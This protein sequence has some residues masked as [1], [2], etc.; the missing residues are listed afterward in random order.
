[1]P[2]RFECLIINNGSDN[3]IEWLAT[4]KNLG[5]WLLKKL[6][7]VPSQPYQIPDA[8]TNYLSTMPLSVDMVNQLPVNV[9]VM[10]SLRNAAESSRAESSDEPVPVV[11]ELS[12]SSLPHKQVEVSQPHYF[13]RAHGR[14]ASK[15]MNHLALLAQNSEALVAVSGNIVVPRLDVCLQVATGKVR[16]FTTGTW[17]GNL[18][19][20]FE[21]TKPINNET[22]LLQVLDENGN[23]IDANDHVRIKFEKFASVVGDADVDE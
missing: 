20:T 23:I 11:V 9:D 2:K 19:M 15:L 10:V 22:F 14:T 4:V 13:V 6:E 21:H 16:P 3:E 18:E 17:F 8:L 5:H 7:P 1:M 12:A